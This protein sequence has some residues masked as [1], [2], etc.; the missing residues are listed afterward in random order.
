MTTTQKSSSRVTKPP[1]RFDGVSN[2]GFDKEMD[3]GQEIDIFGVNCG[4]LRW[5]IGLEKLDVF[6]IL[7]STVTNT[8][9]NNQSDV[10]NNSS[11]M[12]SDASNNVHTMDREYVN[13]QNVLDENE[14]VNTNNM[15]FDNGVNKSFL[16]IVMPTLLS[17]SNK[18]ETVPTMYEEGR[19]VVNFEEE[20]VEEGSKM[21]NITL[22]GYFVGCKMAYMELRYN[23]FKMWGKFGLKDI[24]VQNVQRWDP[25]ISFEKKEQDTIQLW[26]KLG[27]LPLEA[28]N[29]KGWGMLEFWWRLMLKRR[30]RTESL[31]AKQGIC[32]K[33]KNNVTIRSKFV[34]V[35]REWNVP[36][37]VIEAFRKSTNK[38]AVLEDHD[39]DNEINMKYKMTVDSYVKKKIQPTTDVTMKWSLRMVNYFKEQWE[40][41]ISKEDDDIEDVCDDGNDIASSVTTNV[42]KGIGRE[43]LF[44]NTEAMLYLVENI[45][46][47]VKYYS[48]FIYV[49]NSGKERKVLGKTLAV[50]KDIAN[51]LPWVLMGDWNVSLNVSDHSAGGSCK[52]ANMLDF[53]ECIENIEIEDLSSLGMHFTWI[54]S[55]LNP[56]NSTLKKIDR[57]MGISGFLGTFPNAYAVFM[58]HLTSDDCPAML[59]IPNA[60]KKKNKSFKFANYIADKP[61]FKQTVEKDWY[62]EV[63]GCAMFR[64]VKRLKSMKSH[65]K[66]LSWKH[67]NLR[68]EEAST[69][70]VYC[71]AVK[72]GEIFISI[73]KVEW[74]KYR[75]RNSKFF[76]ALLKSKANK[77]RVASIC[78]EKGERHTQIDLLEEIK[79][80]K[81]ISNEDSLDMIRPVSDEEIKHAMFNIDDNK[82]L[83]LMVS[84]LAGIAEIGSCSVSKVSRLYPSVNFRLLSSGSIP[85]YSTSGSTQPEWEE[86]GKFLEKSES[87]AMCFV[88]DNGNGYG[89]TTKGCDYDLVIIGAGVGGHGAALHAVEKQKNCI[90]CNVFVCCCCNTWPPDVELPLELPDYVATYMT[91]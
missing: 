75:D 5:N 45:S 42:M 47:K 86:G 2:G 6:P 40:G 8:V 13:N 10:L 63:K 81:T 62:I 88:A 74:L 37:D 15:G 44:D 41:C 90:L 57:V 50:Y 1:A 31:R 3:I 12:R 43:V 19:E 60:L 17:H 46:M 35:N 85:S 61:E 82:A 53:Q 80:L 38:Y 64:L 78:N 76:H 58:P 30:S 54:Q 23:L 65:M 83:G 89:V 59:N 69:L 9:C 51:K 4:K 48:C 66:A 7:N 27:N 34:N 55:R 84:D 20:I 70:K 71:D 91:A 29:A 33:D 72:D 49:A 22:F 68:K 79:F 32:Y 11:E 16:N 52:T 14:K 87:Y 24:I 77:N 73:G 39:D 21:S 36:E 67:G 26:I 56:G 25:S 28:W 18:L